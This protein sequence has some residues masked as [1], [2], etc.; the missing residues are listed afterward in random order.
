MKASAYIRIRRDKPTKAGSA[1]VYLQFRINSQ[2]DQIPL[3]ISWPVASFDNKRGVFLPRWKDDQLA[4][5]HN[6]YAQ[7]ELGKTNQIFIRYR[8]GNQNLTLERFHRE[9]QQFDL[10][11]DFL[12]WSI[13]DNDERYAAGKIKIQTY[14]NIKSQLKKIQEWRPEIQF[15]TLDKNALETLEAWLRNKANLDQNSIWA[16]M[17]TMKS[18][19]KRASDDNIS[20]DF[21][22]VQKYK[23][24]P[25]KS[26]I[27]YNTPVEIEKLW[28][29]LLS[30]SIP[31]DH[32]KVLRAYLYGTLTGLR[33]SDLERV[34]WKNIQDD[35]LVFEPWKT[36]G[37]CKIV[38]VP[39]P[40]DSWIL[41]ENRKGGLFN[42]PTNQ[43]CN[44]TMKDIAIAS[45]I[46]KN[47]T[48]HVARHTFATEYLRRGGHVHVLKELMGHSKINTTMIYVHVDSD[49]KRKGMRAMGA[50]VSISSPEQRANFEKY[51][52]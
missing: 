45:G 27:V 47:L 25:T 10:R 17:K 15:G 52:A 2:P 44:R 24:P 51:A 13:L 8:L 18:Q 40:E 7:K 14:K 37:M 31:A 3:E 42:L 12:A 16:I 28:N 22:S 1:A 49:M 48:M 30:T 41:I 32:F 4:N 29:Y 5:D 11:K 6:L 9:F 20:F 33:F 36:R 19:A 38:S 23:L 26:R 43:E 50:P 21:E 35:E 46:R 39:L 34:G